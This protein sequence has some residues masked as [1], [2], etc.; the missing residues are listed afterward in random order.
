MNGSLAR[1]S[2][3]SDW[4]KAEMSSCAGADSSR[5]VGTVKVPLPEEP[6]SE[7]SRLAVLLFER[8]LA[9]FGL[10]MVRSE[11]NSQEVKDE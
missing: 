4:V 8:W 1:N 10:H 3:S 5:K 11:I 7:Q 6:V 2:S 9:W